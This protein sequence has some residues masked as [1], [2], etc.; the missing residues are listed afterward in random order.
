MRANIF[1]FAVIA[2]LLVYAHHRYDTEPAYGSGPDGAIIA[3][4]MDRDH[5][6]HHQPQQG[7]ALPLKREV[8]RLGCDPLEPAKFECRFTEKL[9]DPQGNQRSAAQDST[10][11]FVWRDGEWVMVDH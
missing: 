10:A 5:K 2:A 6:V 11:R 8:S 7:R 4:L 1:V 3:A 9:I